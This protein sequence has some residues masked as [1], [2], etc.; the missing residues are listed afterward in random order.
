[1]CHACHPPFFYSFLLRTWGM[2]VIEE[3]S[4]REDDMHRTAV[5]IAVTA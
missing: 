3:N 5:V 1:M 4:K 2:Y